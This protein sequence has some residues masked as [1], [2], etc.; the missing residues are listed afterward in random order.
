[1]GAD[2]IAQRHLRSR[3]P[4]ATPDAM[5]PELHQVIA[6]WL[7]AI[8]RAGGDRDHRTKE[9]VRTIGL[10]TDWHEWDIQRAM[11]IV[12]ENLSPGEARDAATTGTTTDAVGPQRRSA[13]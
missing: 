10:M 1:M 9:A 4:N 2:T 12:A 3:F 6:R 11:K 13:S 5:P 8:S 7:Y